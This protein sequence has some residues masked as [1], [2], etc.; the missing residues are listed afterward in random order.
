MLRV[1]SKP[2]TTHTQHTVAEHGVRGTVALL[3]S[4]S[5]LCFGS[6]D[7]RRKR[8]AWNAAASSG[9]NFSVAHC[10]PCR[11]SPSL[12]QRTHGFL[13]LCLPFLS[14]FLSSSP[15]HS[16][17]RTS[18]GVWRAQRPLFNRVRLR[19]NPRSL[20]TGFAKCTL[21]TQ[22]RRGADSNIY[23]MKKLKHRQDASILCA[24]RSWDVRV[25]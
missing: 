21:L 3:Q 23:S 7:F 14:S 16:F 24:L 5:L 2:T 25:L 17:S 9:C 19:R 20:P 6:D 10:F 22:V 11:Y 18:I 13:S 4:V 8:H 12:F 1:A 15:S